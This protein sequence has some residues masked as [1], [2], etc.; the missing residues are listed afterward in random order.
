MSE[1][2]ICKVKINKI[3]N[4]YFTSEHSVNELVYSV[5]IPFKI[6]LKNSKIKSI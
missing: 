3:D 6:D 4:P 2:L 5:H 1:S